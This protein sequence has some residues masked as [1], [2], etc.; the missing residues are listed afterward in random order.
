MY[1]CLNCGEEFIEPEVISTTYESYYGVAEEFSSHTYL[2]IDVCPYC[3]SKMRYMK[4][5]MKEEE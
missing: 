2:R 4:T 5:N 3:K 1:R